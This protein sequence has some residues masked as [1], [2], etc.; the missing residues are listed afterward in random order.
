[1]SFAHLKIIY[2]FEPCGIFD[3][4]HDVYLNFVPSAM[5]MK[6][7][8]TV[9]TSRISHYCLMSKISSLVPLT[10]KIIILSCYEATTQRNNA[11]RPP[12]PPKPM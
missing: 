1:M 2:I 11:I 9:S 10:T 3:F 12:P 8:I 6:V 7:N 5:S 4:C